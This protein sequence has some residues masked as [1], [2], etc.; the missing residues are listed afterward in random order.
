MF[1]PEGMQEMFAELG[2]AIMMGSE[3]YVR[4]NYPVA[5]LLEEIRRLAPD[6]DV[7]HERGSDLIE[8]IPGG[9]ESAAAHAREADVVVVAI[10]GASGWFAEGFTEGEGSDRADIGLPRAQA[11]LVHAVAGLGKPVVAV[12][13]QGR[14]LAIGAAAD[15][16]AAI[17]TGYFG[18]QSAG[19][20]L[21][22]ALFGEINPG[23]K[24]PVTVPRHS[25]QVPIYH[26]QRTGSGYRRTPA[27][28]HRGYTDMPA[29]PL[30]PFGHGLS[31]TTFAYDTLELAAVEVGTAGSIALGFTVTNTGAVAGAEVVQVYAHQAV[32]G[33]TRPAQELVGFARVEL[34]AGE[35]ARLQ[36]E[37]PAALLAHTGVD[38]T[39]AV[40]PGTVSVSIGSSSD[41]IRLNTE[42]ELT[43]PRREILDADRAFFSTVTRA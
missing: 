20:A 28:V 42:V 30:F 27:D 31:Y 4:A 29:T 34:G 32:S 17:V 41:D 13:Y 38:G 12:L 33:I 43:G 22:E 15:N 8:P 5:T 40:E 1:T 24:L 23:G 9:V 7:C 21:A 2:P 3:P 25:G 35:S 36:V 16:L 37:M 6:V 10:G 11:E 18:G 26:Y 14:P 39:F 19:R